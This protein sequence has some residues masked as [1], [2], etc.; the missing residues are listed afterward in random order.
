[1][2]NVSSS[3]GI[4]KYP[5]LRFPEFSDPWA[6]TQLRCLFTKNTRKNTTGAITNVISNSAKN[7]LIPQ[8][9]YFDK[10]IANVEN[11]A[12]YYIISKNDFVYNPRKSAEAPYGPISR[13]SYEEDG[14][15]SPLYLCF[16]GNEGINAEYF[17]KYFRSSVWYRYIYM[18]GDSGARHDRVSI[19]DETFFEMPIHIPCCA[20]QEKITAFLS[21]LDLKIDS[22]RQLLENLKKYKRGVSNKVFN[23]VHADKDSTIID[24]A[25]AFVLL[26]NN[27]FSRD[28][29]TIEEAEILNIHYGDILVK[30]GAVVDT[31]VDAIPYIREGIDVSKYSSNSYLKNGDVVFADTAEDYAVGKV[32]EIFRADGRKI[33]SGLH[34]MP[35]RPTFICAPMYLG[36]YLNSAAYRVQVLP[37]I[38][39][40]K[41]SSISKSE[42]RKTKL[43]I[44][45]LARQQQIVNVLYA[46]DQRIDHAERILE[47]LKKAKTGLLQHLFV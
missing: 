12:G 33:L 22:H 11:T 19:K 47:A 6:V 45:S 17:E 24:F 14:I 40:A 35:F 27:T 8:K 32:C 3:N 18:S 2:A 21:L 38:Q 34:T 16:S 43:Y 9:D 36:Y 28:C 26:Q 44:P 5:K 25:D 46:L 37:M 15:V 7:G 42:I 1:M 29:L 30:Y 20:E 13:Y 10:D 39:G 41:V 23:E 4:E 31:S